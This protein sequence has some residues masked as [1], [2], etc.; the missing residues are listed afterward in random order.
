MAQA[1]RTFRILVSSTFS[2]L[3]EEGNVLKGDDLRRLQVV[4]CG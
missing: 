4:F 2:D 3:K 1:T